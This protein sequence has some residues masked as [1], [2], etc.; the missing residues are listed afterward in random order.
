[1]NLLEIYFRPKKFELYRGGLVYQILGVLLI[2]KFILWIANQIGYSKLKDSDPC[3]YYIGKG[4]NL[5][6]IRM[7][8]MYARANEIWHLICVVLNL[9]F[10]INI[11]PIFVTLGQIF[12]LI[13]KGTI[14]FSLIFNFYL[15]MIQRYNRVRVYIICNKRY[16]KL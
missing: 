10:L 3:N 2:K 9:Y 16:K 4:I 11:L 8:E 5:D 15:V 1:M 14:I 12:Y 6:F 13:A 7:Y